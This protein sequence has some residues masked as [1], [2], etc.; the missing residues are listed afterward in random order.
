[1]ARS[2]IWGIRKNLADKRKQAVRKESLQ[3]RDALTEQERNGRSLEIVKKLTSLCCYQM[4][5][6]LLTYV[7]YRSEVDTLRLIRQALLEGKRVFVPKVQGMEM[8]FYRITDLSELQTGYR[9]ILEPEA[10]AGASYG[11]YLNGMQGSHPETFSR[12]AMETIPHILLCMPGAAFDR[13]R[14]RIGYGGGFFDRY[15]E[16]LAA[17]RKKGLIQ[18]TT[19]ALAYACQ[20]WEEV[21]WESHDVLPDMVLTEQQIIE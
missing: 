7:S 12:A 15:L 4:A 3:M 13:K 8:E 9:G 14:H 17:Y 11:E 21:P 19:I 18:F 1:M 2:P 5:D 6:V 10:G 20:I 16:R